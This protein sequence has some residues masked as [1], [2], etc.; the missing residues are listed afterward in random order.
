MRIADHY[1]IK[2]GNKSL[3]ITK[4]P[5]AWFSAG[6][7]QAQTMHHSLRN[8]TSDIH[9]MIGLNARTARKPETKHLAMYPVIKLTNRCNLNC[10]HCY[11]EAHD[12]MK[13]GKRDL[14]VHD[15]QN[16]VDYIVKLGNELGEPTLTMQLFGGEPT[17]HKQFPE[18]LDYVRSKGL[19]VR[20]STNAANIKLFQSGDFDK[21]FARMWNGE[22]LSNRISPRRTTR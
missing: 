2:Q 3:F 20:V 21:F 22:C 18:I 19:Y 13:K 6:S 7:E 4:G 14:E 16:F 17:L 1:E 9:R 10:S 12:S 5:S 11:I 15:I 8:E